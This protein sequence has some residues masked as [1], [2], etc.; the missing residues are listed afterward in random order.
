MKAIELNGAAIEMNKLAFSWGRLACARPAARRQ[1]GALQEF[2]RGA[3][4]ADARRDI[5]F[6]A[7][8]LTEY[9]TRPIRSATS[10]RSS[11]SAPPKPR[12]RP[13]R[14]TSRRLLQKACSS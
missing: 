14:M 8:F 1:R 11:A 9:Q 12:A 3:G 10:P 7:K 6:R 4:E 13:V 5:A 2:G